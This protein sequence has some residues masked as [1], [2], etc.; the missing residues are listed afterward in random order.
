[1]IN[2]HSGTPE[3]DPSR[4]TDNLEL[5][6]F[7]QFREEGRIDAKYA[8]PLA[9]KSALTDI[10][11]ALLQY[12]PGPIG[13]KLR[14][15]YY[16][17]RF[18]GQGKCVLIG[19]AA[20]IVQPGRITVGDYAFIDHHVTLNA[21]AGSIHVG[22]RVHIAPYAVI[23]G[24]GGVHLADYSAVGAFAR[25]YSHSEAPIDGKRMS[26]PMIPEKDKGMV[27]APVRIGKDG[28]VGTGAV[29]LPGVTIGEGAIV[30]AN[31]L[32]LARTELRPWTIWAGIPAKMV[33]LRKKVT[34]P[35]S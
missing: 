7:M 9:L 29:V 1:M 22:R 11:F 4:I 16:K 6:A 31:S 15:F 5:K 19:T 21:L 14:Q 17:L 33:G 32:V 8:V 20:D 12:W 10:P 27:T 3:F 24:L 30:S 13:M 26:G 25:I 35:D 18:A 23:S 2:R 28:L 34:V